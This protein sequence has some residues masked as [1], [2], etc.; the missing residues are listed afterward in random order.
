MSTA[1]TVQNTTKSTISKKSKNSQ[2]SIDATIS[3]KYKKKT[4]REH[5]L[6]RPDSYT[7][8]DKHQRILQYIAKHKASGAIDMKEKNVRVIPTLLKIVSE[9][10]DNARDR[11][12][13][14][15]EN[16]SSVKYITDEIHFWVSPESITVQ[17]NG[18][19]VP[20]VKHPTHDVYVPELVFG[21]LLTGSNFNDSEERISG[22]RNGYGAKL[23]N[24]W[25]KEFIVETASNGL[26]YIQHFTE[27]MTVVGEPQITKYGK[28]PYTKITL[29]PD[30]QRL[31]IE[32]FTQDHLDVIFRR[33]LDIAGTP[34]AGSKG[35]RKKLKVYYNDE[36]IPINSFGGYVDLHFP[37]T[38]N[39]IFV[40]VNDRW[41]VAVLP[42]PNCGHKVISYVNSINTY[43]G[44]THVDYVVDQVVTGISQHIRKKNKEI[45]RLSQ[46]L[47]KEHL[48]V[49]IDCLIVNPTFSSQTKEKL[50]SK[51]EDYG[52]ECKI[53]DKVMNKIIATGIADVIVEQLKLRE[54]SNL[55]DKKSRKSD[56]IRGLT[57]LED[58]NDAGTSK[59]EGTSLILT[60]GDSAKGLAM[61]GL[62]VVGQQKYGVFPLKGKLL[63]VRDCSIKTLTENEEIQNLIKILGLRYRADY[64]DPDIFK[65]LRYSRIVIFTDQDEDGFHIKGLLMNFL[66]HYV[67]ELVKN[68]SFVQCLQTPIV[69]ARKGTELREFYSLPRFMEWQE[70]V[71]T[72][73]WKFKYYKGLGTSTAKDA[74]EYFA[75]IENKL[76]RYNWNNEEE[77]AE[78]DSITL[79]FQKDRS[80]D[81]KEWL[82]STDL[83]NHSTID[84]EKDVSFSM[85]VN[86]ELVLF[87]NSDNVRS[88]PMVYDGFKP[89]QRKVLFGA[90][91][92]GLD[93]ESEDVEIKVSQLAGQV[94]DVSAYHHGEASLT[95]TIIG[96]AQDFVG[97]NN[98]N[99]LVPSGQ[100]GTRQL[101]GKDAAS[102]RYTFTRIHPV[103]NKIFRSE[104]D[105]VLNWQQ[106]EGQMIE[107]VTY[108]P[109]IPM[110]LVNGTEGIGTGYSTNMP[111]YN[112]LKII[113]SYQNRLNTGEF[114]ELEPWF[115]GFCGNVEKVEKHKYVTKGIYS[116]DDKTRTIT[117]S[118]LPI[119][120]W[121]AK[122]K[123]LLEKLVDNKTLSNYTTQ[124][125]DV[126][127]NFV[128]H[129]SV[130]AFKTWSENTDK[131]ES[132]LKLTKGFTTSNIHLYKMEEVDGHMRAVIHRYED[133]NDIAE[134]HYQKRLVKYTERK[135]LQLRIYEHTMTSLSNKIRFIKEVIDQTISLQGVSTAKLLE[136]LENTGYAKLARKA[137]LS[138]P[139]IKSHSKPETPSFEYLTS[140]NIL[141][142][143]ADKLAKLEE[144]LA[145]V[146]DTHMTYEAMTVTELWNKELEEAKASIANHYDQWNAEFDKQSASS[147]VISSKKSSKKTSKTAS[148]KK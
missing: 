67:P 11:T 4:L 136:T 82:K 42:I 79:A 66:H 28:K 15:L 5:I 64:T 24:I 72:S 57:K 31:K 140:M 110:I 119:G 142:F 105:M 88:L 12:V 99:V 8:S 7:G 17:N 147:A 98:I 69:K 113:D 81:R 148:K 6:D 40:E 55:E 133:L 16:A 95:G 96:M 39:K 89:S 86:Q 97:A 130:D 47:V 100:F 104:D 91:K 120:M 137:D 144:Q 108:F 52:S 27:N 135:E 14:H 65:T 46:N 70:T 90:K 138:L 80:D 25:S 51:I 73:K 9:I 126:S 34:A 1:E 23:A 35:T 93:K 78:Q 20:I 141:T 118:E 29:V 77:E 74:R 41:R 56:K 36:L 109:I 121:T 94:S 112:P 102:P 30:F 84:D 59:S 129:C 123:E 85:F 75:D 49:M 76:V 18:D 116:I 101:G 143:T 10:I 33:A 146:S 83:E 3:A 54:L 44:G 58:A 124:N 50:T 132:D 68:H 107:P 62:A 127:V 131:L 106:E 117:V 87:S 111:P 21:H 145:D 13:A 48:T 71:D 43:G 26:Q 92:R 125:T 32:H 128:L 63:N 2:E 38:P 37:N 61:G 134:E 122:Y 114:L 22:G 115:R 19:G 45:K 139:S 103:A 60:E 53:D